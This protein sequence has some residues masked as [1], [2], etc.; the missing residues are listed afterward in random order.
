MDLLPVEPIAKELE[1][2]ETEIMKNRCELIES[3]L[4]IL[5][6]MVDD[7]TE[8]NKKLR[9]IVSE[10]YYIVDSMTTDDETDDEEETTAVPIDVYK[11]LSLETKD[12]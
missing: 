2:N 1:L 6:K 12:E 4:K 10:L 11:S 5:Q 3:Q 7:T 8:E 9:K